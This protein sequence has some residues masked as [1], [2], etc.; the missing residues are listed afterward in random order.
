MLGAMLSRPAIRAPGPIG[1]RRESMP[2]ADGFMLSRWEPAGRGALQ[3]DRE[4][5]APEGTFGRES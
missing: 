3:F 4:S 1:H 2:P 5:M